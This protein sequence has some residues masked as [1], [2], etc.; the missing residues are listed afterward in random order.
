MRM[1]SRSIVAAAACTL[2]ASAVTA[3]PRILVVSR[4]EAALKVFD[5]DTYEPLFLVKVPGEPH[6][7]A[8]SPD[9]RFAYVADYSGLD[10]T[11]SIIDLE[12]Q[13]RA[14]SVNVKPSYKPHG[15]AVTRDGSR[16]YVTC[17]A[18][19]AVVELDLAARAVKRTFALRDYGV[20]ILTL[21][22]DEKWLYA[23]SQM[24]GT[25][26]FVDVATG[27]LDRTVLS[28]QGCEGIA[29][30]PDGSEIW[31]I[32]RLLQTIAVIKSDA[33]KREATISAVGNP[34]RIRFTADGSTAIVS[35]ALKNEL[36]LF[37]REKRE[38]TGRV[39]VGDFPLVIEISPDGKRWFV[40]NE[41]SGNVSV[42]DAASRQQVK[43][44]PVGANP[45][46]IVYVK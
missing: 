25:V 1:T 6:D 29:V 15:L 31:A 16:L 28:G 2:L 5:A 19:R 43:T 13:E 14:A 17:E 7:V 3:S 23:T 8:A 45:E 34:I 41:H 18:S 24:N 44:F 39:L 36:A 12:K 46:G 21:S 35:C 20:H 10:N 40:T 32:N 38:E 26:S 30:T 11:V 22:P 4:G 37:D 33:H 42:V 27:Q 9:G